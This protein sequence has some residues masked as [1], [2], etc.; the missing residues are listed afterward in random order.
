[1][2]EEEENQNRLRIKEVELDTHYRLKFLTESLDNIKHFFEEFK[3]YVNTS[4]G[5]MDR[6]IHDITMTLE[7]FMDKQEQRNE[8]IWTRLNVITLLVLLQLFEVN[9]NLQELAASALFKF[10]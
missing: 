5:E 1:M 2:G 4:I 10:F 9:I 6:K 7:E 8:K 3:S